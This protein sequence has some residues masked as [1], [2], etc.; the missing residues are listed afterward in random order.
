MITQA[1]KLMNLTEDTE[2]HIFRGFLF[3][4]LPVL[5]L[6]GGGKELCNRNISHKYIF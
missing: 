4:L 5:G 6:E 1:V 2:S 3:W